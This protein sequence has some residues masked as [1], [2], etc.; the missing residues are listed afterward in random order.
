[1]CGNRTDPAE[2]WVLGPSGSPEVPG[3]QWTKD[4][5]PRGRTWNQEPRTEDGG[6]T[7]VKDALDLGAQGDDGIDAGRPPSREI[8][9]DERQRRQGDGHRD[10]GHRIPGP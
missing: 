3:P 4:K 9:R 7:E 2:S 8:G 10:I 5:G 1:M 6:Y